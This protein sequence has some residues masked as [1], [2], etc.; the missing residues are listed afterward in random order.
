MV[1]QLDA[2]RPAAAADRCKTAVSGFTVNEVAEAGSVSLL[3]RESGDCLSLIFGNQIVS[4]EG[5]EVLVYGHEELS[6]AGKSLE[7][8]LGAAEAQ[9]ALT[10]LPW[11]FGKW[12]GSR[13]QVLKRL[14]NKLD[15]SINDTFRLFVGDSATRPTFSAP[16]EILAEAKDQG[17]R[18]LPGSDPLPFTSERDRLGRF[19]FQINRQG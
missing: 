3:C 15:G 7:E 1:S 19:W 8:I 18:N 10:I 12:T 9:G 4:S 11:G 13:R 17:L 5:L 16:S 2:G 14:L 6:V